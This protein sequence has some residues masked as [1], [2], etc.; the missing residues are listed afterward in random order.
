M[1]RAEFFK[2]NKGNFVKYIVK[3]HSGYD[4]I[5]K[6][7]VCAAIS[8]L[9]QTGLLAL[10]KVCEVNVE[11]LLEEGSIEVKIP[12]NI[13]DKTKKKC[14]IVINTILVGLENISESYPEN[15]TL[16]YREV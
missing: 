7:I 2:D 10:K 5:G 15:I 16:K 14:N 3:G 9:T 13:N 6:D 11:Y 1:T 8:T 12:Q 4:E